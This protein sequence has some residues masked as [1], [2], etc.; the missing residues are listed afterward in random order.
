MSRKHPFIHLTLLVLILGTILSPAFA[1]EPSVP[2]SSGGW[3]NPRLLGGVD[4]E[5]NSGITVHGDYG[6]VLSESEGIYVLNVSDV[7]N[8]TEISFF[9][10]NVSGQAVN[11]RIEHNVLYLACQE[12]GVLV[13]DIEDPEHLVLLGYYNESTQIVRDVVVQDSIVF[14]S[15]EAYGIRIVNFTNPALPV[16][17]GNYSTAS[18]VP[19]RLFLSDNML[20]VVLEE[21]GFH[22]IDITD[23]ANPFLISDLNSLGYP[24]SIYVANNFAYLAHSQIEDEDDPGMEIFDITTP[25]SPTLIGVYDTPAFNLMVINDTVYLSCGLTGFHIVNVSQ[26]SS[27][28]LLKMYGTYVY[29]LDVVDNAIFASENR[30]GVRIYDSGLDSD[31]DGVSDWEETSLFMTNPFNSDSDGD[32]YSDSEE[33]GKGTDPL[34]PLDYPI[35]TKWYEYVLVIGFVVV[36]FLGSVLIFRAV[37]NRYTKP[38]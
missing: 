1:S 19:R 3:L 12:S 30:N 29:S 7:E 23:V 4:Y 10:K 36:S 8:P 32:G 25:A 26:P 38:E 20:F 14:I 17:I 27:P 33:I 22:I 9:A 13:V 16:Q 6:Y 34:N 2:H 21:Y 35:P 24:S 15:D 28:V 11:F 5:D 31:E 18:L 37:I